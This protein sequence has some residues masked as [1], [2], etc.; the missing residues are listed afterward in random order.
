MAGWNHDNADWKLKVCLSCKKEF[1]PKS[2]VQ[3]FCSTPCRGRW[4]YIAGTCSTENQ[5]KEIS[6][7]WVRYLARLQYCSGRKRDELTTEILLKK[8][9]AQNYRCAL[10]GVEMTCSLE[11]GKKFPYNVSVD[12]IQAGGPYSEDN[13]QLVCRVLNSWRSDTDLPFFIDM[14]KKVAKNFTERDCE[15]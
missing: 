1:K 9:K 13:I 7:N 14:C 8:L 6:G 4:K 12:R 11:V 15:V 3:K 10:S 2:G 5:Y